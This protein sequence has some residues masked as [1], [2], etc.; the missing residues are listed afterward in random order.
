[1]PS[2]CS[3]ARTSLG[4]TQCGGDM[5]R[6]L[7]R[8]EQIKNVWRW[9]IATCLA[10]HPYIVVRMGCRLG[11]H[12]GAYRLARLAYGPEIVLRDLLDRFFDDCLRRAEARGKR[13]VSACGVYLPD[14]EHPRRPTC[15]PGSCGCVSWPAT[16]DG[17]PRIEAKGCPTC[18]PIFRNQRPGRH[19]HP[20][21][22]RPRQDWQPPAIPRDLP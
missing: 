18:V 9:T 14:V 21:R 8:G 5:I 11:S 3:G 12:H 6:A 17:W 20:V 22:H 10:L 1:M 7:T 19:P 13:G 16:I 2:F 15:R 4:S